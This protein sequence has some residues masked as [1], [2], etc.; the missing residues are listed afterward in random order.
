MILFEQRL[1][2][3]YESVPHFSV[4]SH[5]RILA[6]LSEFDE[7]QMWI[8]E[9]AKPLILNNPSII[10]KKELFIFPQTVLIQKLKKY[11]MEFLYYIIDGYPSHDDSYEMKHIAV[12][13]I[14]SGLINLYK[15]C[16]LAEKRAFPYTEKLVTHV[17]TTRIY[18]E[19]VDIFEQIYRLLDN[20]NT[21][22]FW[23]NIE[24]AR[25]MLIYDDMY[26][27][28]RRI[29]ALIDESLLENGCEVEW[30]KAGYNNID[31]FL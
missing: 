17:K 23:D 6:K 2:L 8:W 19:C 5:D 16:Y 25:G 7:V 11:Y 18:N 21:N 29:S 10:F 30:V 15:F 9:N 3:F 14:L 22:N 24:K 27:S 4:L 31:D 26:E 12:Y 20:L 1:F 28:S 13:S